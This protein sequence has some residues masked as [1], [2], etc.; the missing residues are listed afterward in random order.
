MSRP[1]LS[2]IAITLAAALLAVAPALLAAQQPSA[3][4][5]VSPPQQPYHIIDHWNIGGEGGWD[6]LNVDPVAHRLYIAH[7]TEV[8]VVDI[9][10]GKSI[11][12]IPGL[13]GV[14]GVALDSA[15]KF[16]YISDGG[17]NAVVAFDRSALAVVA[18]IPA[19]TNPDCIIFEPAT[20]TV[21]AFNG[22]SHDISVI[23]PASNTVIATIPLPGKPEF[24]V[25]DGQGTVFDNLEDKSEIVRIDARSKTITA[26]WP[27]GCD[28]PSGL[29]IDVAGHRL[30]PACDGK[31]ASVIDSTS[32]KLLAN[33]TIGDGPDAAG[34]SDAHSLAFVPSRDGILSVIDAA[35]P[36][37]PTIESLTTQAGARTMTYDPSTDRVYLITA[38]LGP[39]PD[40]TPANPRPRPPVIPGTFTV[41]VVG[42]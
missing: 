22:R 8:D 16:G 26:T 9:N 12:V 19:G 11:G 40:P 24:A 27:A 6:Y 10:T 29:A 33:S 5:S 25:T 15:G 35:A 37:Y 31:K 34:F 3:P 17:G 23:S 2:L 7:G 18:T 13:H 38:D 14:H 1:H 20:K 28:S 42:R 21:W 4:T 39:R 36:G 32:G 41:I 30:F